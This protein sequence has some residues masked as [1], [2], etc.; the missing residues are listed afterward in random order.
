MALVAI[1]AAIQQRR[2]RRNSGREFH[3]PLIQSFNGNKQRFRATSRNF[4]SSSSNGG[5]P[6]PIL[7]PSSDSSCS[8]QCT[9]MTPYASFASH[10]ELPLHQHQNTVSGSLSLAVNYDKE[11]KSL[12]VCKVL[13]WLHFQNQQTQTSIL[14]SSISHL[15]KFPNIITVKTAF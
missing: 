6:P 1:F 11:A 14:S 9:P 4:G 15:R 2:Q 5:S 12:Q 3:S 13:Q 8:P 7:S 10:A